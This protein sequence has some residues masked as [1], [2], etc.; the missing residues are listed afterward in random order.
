MFVL[1]TTIC[2][3]LIVLVLAF[4]IMTK[5]A[6]KRDTSYFAGKM[7]AHRGLHGDG[8]PE[9]SITAFKLACEN[10]YGA[11][12]DVQMTSDGQLVV[13]HDGNL[14]R[15]C[16]VDKKLKDCTYEE[17]CTYRL[18]ETDEKIPLLSE[19]LEALGGVDLVCEI[20]ADN[21]AKNYTLC[22]KTYDLLKDYKGRFC[23]ESFSPFLMRWFMKK[24][25]EIIRGQLSENFIKTFG[26]NPVHFCMAEL[27][28]DII[29]KPDFI[30]YNHK[31]KTLGWHIVKLLY[32][33]L[34]FAWTARGDEEIESAKKD[35]DS[36]IFEKYARTD[37]PP[38]IDNIEDDV[39]E[40]EALDKDMLDKE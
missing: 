8:V 7:Y 38:E 34:W 31:H 10:G 27:L 36:I 29:S 15:M 18:K 21:G 9:N 20:K 1:L 17:L 28:H 4:V 22:K 25:P 5:P 39:I 23:V 40:S 33:P 35:Y 3:V 37:D 32:R 14:N 2:V 6:R 16:G 12:L 26:L 24:H 13:F 30:S 11:E 19:A